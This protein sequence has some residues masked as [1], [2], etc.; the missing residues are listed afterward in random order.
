MQGQI[1]GRVEDGDVMNKELDDELSEE[2]LLNL[3]MDSMTL[4]N[5][6]EW[7]GFENMMDDSLSDKIDHT[8]HTIHD[9]QKDGSV[10]LDEKAK[11]NEL[12]GLTDENRQLIEGIDGLKRD[13]G[14]DDITNDWLMDGWKVNRGCIVNVDGQE[15]ERTNKLLMLRMIQCGG[16]LRL[17][18]EW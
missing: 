15:V 4:M 11:S 6:I 9:I 5:D 3:T 2:L 17:G 13:G 12:Q 7:D 8:D 16:N 10:Q 1:I 18:G 14:V